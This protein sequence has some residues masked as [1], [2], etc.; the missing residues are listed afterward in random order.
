VSIRGNIGWSESNLRGI[1]EKGQGQ[2]LTLLFL[3]VFEPE[4][5]NSIGRL[6]VK[7]GRFKKALPPSESI[8]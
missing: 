5:V 3:F 2:K 7:T 8:D 1:R 6:G 4:I